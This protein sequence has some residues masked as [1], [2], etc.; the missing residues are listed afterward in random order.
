MAEDLSA[1]LTYGRLG[2]VTY[3]T[4]RQEWHLQKPLQRRESNSSGMFELF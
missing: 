1:D 2:E 4:I 3:D